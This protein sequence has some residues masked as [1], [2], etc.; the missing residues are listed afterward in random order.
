M[1]ALQALLLAALMGS[2][3]AQDASDEAVPERASK[4]PVAIVF[5]P[6][7][8]EGDIV[9]GIFDGRGKLRRTLRYAPESPELTID[10]NGYIARWDGRDDAGGLCPAGRYEAR[11]FVV[12]EEVAVEGRDFHF[13]DWMAED[14]IPATGVKL[15]E[16]REGFGVELITPKGSVFRRIQADGSLA[17][18]ASPQFG[19]LRSMPAGMLAAKSAWA[20]G[21][22]GTMWGILDLD[23]QRAVLQVGKDGD[24]LRVLRIPRDEPQPV[25]VLASSAEDAIL[26]NEK[27]DDGTLRVRMLRRSDQSTTENG[28]VT[29][30][31]EVVFERGMTPFA[32]FGI[33]DGKLVRR[34]HDGPESLTIALV[35]N[36]LEKGPRKVELWARPRNPGSGLGMGDGL[37]L[38][39]V[40]SEGDWSRF[41]LT[42]DGREATLYQSDGVVVEE[43]AIRNL[44]HIAA[45]DAGSF[46]LAAPEQ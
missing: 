2:A 9:L 27:G 42:G 22:D 45:F 3:P 11:G 19:S 24:A 4:P 31:W 5:T 25:E 44:D 28:R 33:A 43:F 40:S 6:P 29:A 35:P 8:L 13:N 12:G 10:T 17:D 39:E 20:T 18:M 16:W 36:A 32:A 14:R 15:C 1:R 21:R 34:A 30:D 38:V 46:L 26:L 7:D 37:P 23:G 41:A